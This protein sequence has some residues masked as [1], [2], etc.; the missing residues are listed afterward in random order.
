MSAESHTH[1]EIS[2]ASVLKFVLVIVA[3]LALY[4]LKEVIGIFLFALIIASAIAP[5]ADW[6]E[7]K[8]LP[9]VLGVLLLYLVVFG[10]AALLLSL[11]VPYVS[12]ELLQ[13][14]VNLPIIL[15][16]VTTS[17]DTVQQQ[18]SKYFD[19]ASEIQNML[20]YFSAYLQQF[21]QSAIGIIVSIFGGIFSFAAIVII[22]FYLSVMKGGIDTFMKSV[23]PEKYEAYVVSLWKR[24]EAKVG[25]WLQGQ[26][27]LA[28]IVGLA[29]YVGLSL[30]HVKFALILGVLA[31]IL[32]IVPI[33]GPVLAAIPGVLLGFLGSPVQGLWILLFYF[34][35]QQLE[36][37]ILA[38]II[39]G[40]TT[41]LNPVTVIIA[42]LVGGQ[43]AGISG[44]LLAVPIATVIVEILDDLAKRKELKRGSV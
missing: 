19:F 44:M 37:H 3:L 40:K 35:V 34:A 14:T 20:D 27:L 7:S 5:F 16:K 42:L 2:L 11:I 8:G 43:L 9:R 29:V 33:A 15:T 1:I 32:E 18:S 12:Q 28:L 25:R 24:S 4:L 31:M 13:L 30:M 21:S 38:P 17:L 39:L 23:M 26:M 6:L 36:N 10:L 41:G 22:S